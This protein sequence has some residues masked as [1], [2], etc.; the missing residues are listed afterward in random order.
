[1]PLTLYEVDFAD[2]HEIAKFARGFVN[3][4][5]EIS[6]MVFCAGTMLDDAE[7]CYFSVASFRPQRIV[8]MHPGVVPG[9]L[10]RHTN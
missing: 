4:C 10:Y 7:I 3:R 9:T 1:M 5:G 6:V 2:P 8:T